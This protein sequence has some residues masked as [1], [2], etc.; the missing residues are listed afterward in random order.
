MM[1]T[2][3]SILQASLEKHNETFETL[4]SLIPAKY[5]LVPDDN[6]DQVG[7]HCP[8]VRAYLQ[9][10]HRVHL[11]ITRIKRCSRHQN[12][13]SKRRPRKRVVKRYARLY[14]FRWTYVSLMGR[15]SIQRTIKAY[16]IFKAINQPLTARASKRQP[17]LMTRMWTYYRE[18]QIFSCRMLRVT[19]KSS[20]ATM[21]RYPDLRVLKLFAPN[22]TRK[23]KQCEARNGATVK[24]I[25][26]TSYWRNAGYTALQCASVGGRRRRPK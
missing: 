23:L 15:S 26:K 17:C 8:A 18:K 11:D 12:R 7:F 6:N 2:A 4:L 19:Q 22:Y 21:S 10:N 25:A 14:L 20:Q 1:P 5:Y 16:W 9:N 3:T 24:G 13:L